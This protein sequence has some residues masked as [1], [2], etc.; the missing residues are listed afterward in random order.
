MMRWGLLHIQ[1]A[2][3][4]VSVHLEEG[5]DMTCTL[6][7]GIG[8][9]LPDFGAAELHSCLRPG[10]AGDRSILIVLFIAP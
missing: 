1:F 5:G 8:Q 10:N 4:E 7:S 3:D 2:R 9:R 6:C